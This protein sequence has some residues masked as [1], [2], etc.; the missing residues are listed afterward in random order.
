MITPPHY[1]TTQLQPIEVIRSL[2]S[3]S[4]FRAFCIGNIIKYLGRYQH[5]G[6]ALGDLRKARDYL[7]W[8]IQS[9]EG[10]GEVR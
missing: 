1:Q 4:E 2:F 10:D 7:E 8:A 5:K 6:D 9:L 3:P